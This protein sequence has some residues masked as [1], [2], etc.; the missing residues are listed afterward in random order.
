M[1]V[2]LYA[3]RLAAHA[4]VA[5]ND[6]RLLQRARRLLCQLQD[7]IRDELILARGRRRNRG[8]MA[9]VAA[10]TAADTIYHIDKL[11]EETLLAWMEQ[12]W[13]RAWPVELIMEGLEEVHTFPL[14]TA[15]ADTQWKLI[16]DPID[17]TRG[18]M[19]D[20]RSA[21]VLAG[22]APQR[23]RRN[24]LG[25]IQVAA[26]TELP[27][28]KQWRADQFSAVAGSGRVVAT[29][30][31]VRS[32]QRARLAVQLSTARNFDH[33]FATVSRFFPTAK[34]WLSEIEEALWRELG[35]L[36]DGG[37]PP[38]VFEDQY[39]S[40]G[41][42]LAEML[43]GH[44]RMVLDIRPE[45]FRALGVADAGLS[46]HPYDLCTELILREAGG[47]VERPTGG[48]LRDP[49]DTTSPVSWAAYAN[50]HLARKVRPVLKRL[51]AERGPTG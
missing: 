29:S 19:H 49:L 24:H 6:D 44:D 23:G 7:L 31:D 26:M 3:G 33:G 39:I 41:G 14:G 9:D 10:H 17:G 42:Q 48:R 1:T 34:T 32:G 46:S 50:P 35:V 51:L 38:P 28:T 20:K 13:P 8:R 37:E 21:W 2:T 27:I 30:L 4:D 11:S 12:H 40:C 36:Q 16:I 15:M 43:L 18:L 22:L 45:A 47:V 5:M 25:D